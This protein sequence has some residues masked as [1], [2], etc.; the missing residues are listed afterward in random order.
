MTSINFLFKT[1]SSDPFY[2]PSFFNVKV[3]LGY[4][5]ATSMLF[6]FIKKSF[7]SFTI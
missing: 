7:Y 6:F 1:L 4:T 3:K 5:Y 2:Q